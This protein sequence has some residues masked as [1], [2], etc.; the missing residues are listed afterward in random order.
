M[1][2]SR[3]ALLVP[4]LLVGCGPVR[5]D[6][7]PFP[8][9][10][11]VDLSHAYD[12]QTI[13][14]PTAEA[15][16]LEKEFEGM[17]EGGYYYAANRFRMSEHGG[18]HIDAPIHFHQSGATVDRIPLEQLMGAGVVVDVTE[19]CGKD[20]DY[21][22]SVDDLLR[23]EK[24]NGTIPEGTIVFFRTG[25]GRFWPDRTRYLGTDERG[26]QA[27]PKLHFPGLDPE[28]ARWL[29]AHRGIR[30]VGLDTA[31]IDCGQSKLFETHRIL[32]EKEIPAFENLANLDRLPARGFEV[33]AL[34]MKIKGGSGGPLRA[35][36]IL[37]ISEPARP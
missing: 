11:L 37:P 24:A 2:R 16:V 18:T 8:S 36:A 19:A 33:I 13:F 21:R 23:W 10:H 25:F 22:I 35:V 32:F 7:H 17:T 31:S 3:L 6:R 27:V 20:P 9:G 26:P 30:A 29:V 28:A 15:F 14:W 12:D 5:P 4:L 34:P 1:S